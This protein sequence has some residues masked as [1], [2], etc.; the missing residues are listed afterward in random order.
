MEINRSR[1]A[2]RVSMKLEQINNIVDWQSLLEM[3]Q[4]VDRTDAEKGGCPHKDLLVK[5]KMLFLQS[6]FIGF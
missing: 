4:I 5:V 2:S 6:L 1:K 3:V